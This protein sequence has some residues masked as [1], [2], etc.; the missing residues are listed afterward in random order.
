MRIVGVDLGYGYVKAAAGG[1]A[2]IMFPSVVGAVRD[3][4]L[5]AGIGANNIG[6]RV[7][8]NADE[9]FVGELAI[10]ES[11]DPVRPFGQ[12]KIDHP[13]TK[14]LLATALSLVGG[15]TVHLVTGLPIRH[16]A[17]QKDAMRDALRGFQAEVRVYEKDIQAHVK[18][19]ELTVF[20][21][22]AGALFGAML[23]AANG[24]LDEPDLLHPSGLIACVDVGYRTTDVCVLD[25][26]A[27]FALIH[28]MSDTF[29]VGMGQAAEAVREQLSTESGRGV[30][31]RAVEAALD[32]VDGGLFWW[33]DK[34]YDLSEYAQPAL[35]ELAATLA[36][37]LERLW[38]DDAD[39]VRKTLIAGG[40]GLR[41]APWL[42]NLLPGAVALDDP[43][44]A[45]AVGFYHVAMDRARRLQ[46]A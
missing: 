41:L 34:E 40:G 42:S 6:Y 30:P 44:M 43:Q 25:A 15:G 1:D 8:V 32:D 14:I 7:A 23:A 45:N 28:R 46:R 17:A 24:L 37:A 21:Q 38:G 36:A 18:I 29:D 4:S 2:R 33:R 39:R 26:G 22:S 16:Y 3:L 31:L 9:K 35:Q 5:A 20:P 27:D 10:R 19:E 12:E 11:L 13:A